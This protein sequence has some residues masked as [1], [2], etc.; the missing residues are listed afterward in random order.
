VR[1]FDAA[2][3]VILAPLGRAN[4]PEGERLDLAR[5]ARE[6]GAKAETP[7]NVE[8]IVA[9]LAGGAKPG[10]TIAVLSNGAFG[11]LHEKL[12]AALA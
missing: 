5:L 12:L 9:R 10:D 3:R 6:I 7:A 1:A 2:D 11:G 4:V 8:A